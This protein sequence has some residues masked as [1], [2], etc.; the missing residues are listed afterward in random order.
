MLLNTIYTALLVLLAVPVADVKADGT[1]PKR[2][3]VEPL[4]LSFAVPPQEP[5][6]HLAIPGVGKIR[7]PKLGAVPKQEATPEQK[8]EAIFSFYLGLFAR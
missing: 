8:L 6:P 2:Q 5:S 3:V 4:A 7:V 1:T